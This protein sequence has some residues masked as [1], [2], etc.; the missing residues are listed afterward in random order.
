MNRITLASVLT[1][2][3][4]PINTATDACST[5][6]SFCRAITNTFSDRGSEAIGKRR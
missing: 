3:K 6:A 4:V 1:D 2:A 5:Q